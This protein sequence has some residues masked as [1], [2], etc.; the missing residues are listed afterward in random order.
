MQDVSNQD[1]TEDAS[2]PTADYLV[3]LGQRVRQE[4]ARTKLSRRALS[5]RS[6]VSERFIAH[7]EAGQGNISILRLKSIADAL[8]VPLPMLVADRRNGSGRNGASVVDFDAVRPEMVA[9][10]YRRA[11]PS[12]R[13]AVV[14]I[15]THAVR[16]SRAA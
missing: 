1:R 2:G 8:H 10:L 15:L 6:G 3:A 13:I 7:L 12:D 11:E 16:R 5:E 4:R 14:D 9:E